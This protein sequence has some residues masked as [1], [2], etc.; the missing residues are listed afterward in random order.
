V[1]GAFD[2]DVT[3]DDKYLSTVGVKISRRMV[4]RSYG[5]M[6]LMVWDLAGGDDFTP[7]SSYL[8]GAAGALI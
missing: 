7:Q 6:G 8:R 1:L 3:Y 2:I 5:E 4:M